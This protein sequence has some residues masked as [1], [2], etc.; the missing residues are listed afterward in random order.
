[1]QV[2]NV[3][4]PACQ[5]F[6]FKCVYFPACQRILSKSVPRYFGTDFPSWDPL[7]DAA[8]AGPWTSMAPVA[9]L[10]PALGSTLVQALGATAV[11]RRSSLKLLR[12]SAARRP[13]DYARYVLGPVPASYL[14]GL[15][16]ITGVPAPRHAEPHTFRI[17]LLV[18]A[19]H[20]RKTV[21]N[22]N[23]HDIGLQN[24]CK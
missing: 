3:V 10:T 22:Y 13:L 19:S 23:V 2:N 7:S 17:E 5:R 21:E 6:S 16:P 24:M 9:L 8:V 11:R 12:R 15:V 20:A 4:L 14:Q 1:M 18:W